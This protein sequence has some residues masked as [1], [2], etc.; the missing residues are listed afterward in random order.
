MIDTQFACRV[1]VL[2]S[3][4]I[5]FNNSNPV[6][7]NSTG[8]IGRNGT[9]TGSAQP[10]ISVTEIVEPVLTVKVPTIMPTFV[11]PKP[12]SKLYHTKTK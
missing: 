7:V 8:N 3:I 1:C 12:A 10:N 2:P 11:R 9:E 6:G 5:G 4:P